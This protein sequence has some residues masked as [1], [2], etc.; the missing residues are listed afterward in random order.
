[1]YDVFLKLTLKFILN[2]LPEDE[3]LD[4]DLIFRYHDF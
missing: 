4:T 3:Q 2:V 1:M